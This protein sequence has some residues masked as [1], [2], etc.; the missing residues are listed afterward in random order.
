[1]AEVYLLNFVTL[2]L[3]HLIKFVNSPESEIE[4]SIILV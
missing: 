2:S 1:M 4:K 3:K